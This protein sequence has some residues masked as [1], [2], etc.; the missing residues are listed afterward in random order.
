MTKALVL[1]ASPKKDGNTATMADQF[2]AG[3]TAS[4]E[5]TVHEFY[6]NDLSIRPCQGCNA[7]IRPPHSGCVIDDDFQKIVPVFREAD[8]VVFAAPIYW[9]HLCAQL[10]TFIDRMHP[11][12]TFDRDHCLPTKDLVL[13]TAYFA[14]DPYG[15]QLA[16]K[17]L[18]SISG[19]AGMSF[20]VVSF[21][22]DRGHVRDDPAKLA[23]ANDLGRSFAGRAKPELPIACVV[24]GCGFKFRDIEHAAMH[25]VMAAGAPHLKWKAAHL[26]ALHDLCNTH[27]LVDEVCS[28]LRRLHAQEDSKL[29]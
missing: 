20:D 24:D 17:T 21:H 10:K 19:W 1:K 9:W 3:L 2:V 28:I 5:A 6:L 27:Q 26:S 15:V 13:I 12:L 29:P 16:V 25:I 8:L 7:C 4:G 18:E 14:E 22:A 23:E 11:V